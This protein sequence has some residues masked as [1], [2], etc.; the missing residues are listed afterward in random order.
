MLIG[1]LAETRSGRGATNTEVDEAAS[2]LLSP[3]AAPIEALWRECSEE[4]CGDI[5][6]LARGELSAAD[7]PADRVKFLVERGIASRSGNRVR[8]SNRFIERLA[9]ERRNDVSGAKRLFEKPEDFA[10]NIR[11]VLELRIGHVPPGDPQLMKLV[12]RAVK[13]LPD[14]PDAALGNARD[15]LDRALD[16]VWSVEAPG[17]TVPA[18]WIDAWKF[19]PNLKDLV[20]GYVRDPRLPDA[21]GKQCGLLRIATGGQFVKPLTKRVSRPTYVLLEHMSHVGDLRNHTKGEPTLSMAVSF[22]MAA[23]ELTESLGRDLAP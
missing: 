13:H 18:A 11:T 21:R 9:G 20:A 8:L 15:I 1:R 6:Q 10:T 17:G 14:E 3:V 22:C 2:N 7:L 12:R 5:V 19:N 23:I 16:L 4:S